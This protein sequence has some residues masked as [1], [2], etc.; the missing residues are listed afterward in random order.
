MLDYFVN[1]IG[2]LGEWGYLVILLGAMLESAA[3]VGPVIPGEG[4][5]LVAGFLAAQGA[6]DL[7]VLIFS[8]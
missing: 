8:I 6:L 4:L 5:V 1:L 7:N 2:R 3:F